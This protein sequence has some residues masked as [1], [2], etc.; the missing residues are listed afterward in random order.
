[1]LNVSDWAQIT[2][3]VTLLSSVLKPIL[4][5]HVPGFQMKAGASNVTH[6]NLLRLLNLLLCAGGVLWVASTRGGMS[7]ANIIPLLYY[8][9][10]Q[11]VSSQGLYM[12]TTRAGQ[13]IGGGVGGLSGLQAQLQAALDALGSLGSF[14]SVVAPAPA[15]VTTTSSASSAATSAATSAA[16]SAAD[17][18]TSATTSASDAAPDASANTGAS[19]SAS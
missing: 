14:A 18:A 8:T 2:V 16:V 17:T 13:S 3:I 4:E 9:A 6:D 7:A 10:Q 11:F 1:M 19:T 5:Q 15:T 12:V